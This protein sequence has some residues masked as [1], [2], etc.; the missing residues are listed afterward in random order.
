[1][2]KSRTSK[3]VSRR[4]AKAQRLGKKQL[5]V[6]NLCVSASLREFVYFFTPSEC[7]RH[8]AMDTLC[9]V[10]FSEAW[11]WKSVTRK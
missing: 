10:N 7:L 5:L 6:S 3:F 8:F 11:V 2:K 9:P 4:D 1:V